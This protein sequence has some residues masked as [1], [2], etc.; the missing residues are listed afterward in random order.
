MVFKLFA[1][2]VRL[3]SLGNYFRRVQEISPSNGSKIRIPETVI[4]LEGPSRVTQTEFNFLFKSYILKKYDKM[5][6]CK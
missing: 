4:F 1:R 5:Y 2:S 3:W 6:T